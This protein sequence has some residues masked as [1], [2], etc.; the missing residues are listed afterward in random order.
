MSL[1]ANYL[2]ERT[3][4]KILE[5]DRGFAVYRMLPEQKAVYIIDIFVHPDFRKTGLATQ[6]A[7]EIAGIAK[8]EGFSEMFGSVVP[9]CKGSADS[10][11]VLLAYGMRVEYAVNDFIVFKRAI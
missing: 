9:S 10:V 2:T 4:D 7:D 3:N 5:S 11:R 1:Y 6:M 8:K